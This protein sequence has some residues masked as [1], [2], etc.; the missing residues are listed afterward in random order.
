M[1]LHPEAKVRITSLLSDGLKNLVVKNGQFL[2]RVSAFLAFMPANA[3]LPKDRKKADK[4]HEWIG[5]LPLV[6][7]CSDYLYDKLSL[8]SPYISGDDRRAL[9][10][11]SGYEDVQKIS[12]ELVESFASLPWKYRLT[13]PLNSGMFPPLSDDATEYS[14][15]E[16]SSLIVSNL[17]INENT[18]LKTD[19]DGIRKRISG[20]GV[21][22]LLSNSEDIWQEADYFFQ[23]EIEGFIG[24]FGGGTPMDIIES[25]F[26]AFCG[27]GLALGIFKYEYKYDPT[28]A[29]GHWYVHRATEG[30]WDLR[31]RLNLAG[32]DAILLRSVTVGGG[33]G[34]S[35]RQKEEW[36]NS[37]FLKL[38]KILSHL[39][40]ASIRLAAQWYWDSYK[41]TD[42]V[43]EYVRRMISLEILLGEGAD[44]AKA[45]LG[46]I[47]GNRLAYLVGK[48]HEGRSKTLADFKDIYNIR[49]K[50]LHRGK[51]RL[52]GDDRSAKMKLN[53]LCK[54]AIREE[55]R[56]LVDDDR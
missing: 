43:L 38:Q 30:E 3:S 11:I 28:P 40:S 45:S 50:I 17:L 39:N 15:G 1:N 12:N 36:L 20:S 47:L 4:L 5:D 54:Q 35:Q 26:K 22:S 49:S 34:Q 25:R 31:D 33:E 13:L 44:T 14:V 9:P 53:N 48:T 27:L 19:N 52:V 2:D 55:A 6:E 21:L 18:P 42:E 7:F 24:P 8:N 29:K 10:Q 23:S 16:S 32:E 41:G 46:E 56:L 37:A 51:H